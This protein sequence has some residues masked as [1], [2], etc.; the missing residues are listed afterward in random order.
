MKL[1]LE[2][3]TNLVSLGEKA[4]DLLVKI[5]DEE[6]PKSQ[7]STKTDIKLKEV[8]SQIYKICPLLSDSYI[9]MYN[10]IQEQK[11]SSRDTYYK[12]LRKS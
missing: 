12:R 3:K 8:L 9:L 1:S 4:S 5:I 11:I 6:L 10:Y 7:Q 2:Q